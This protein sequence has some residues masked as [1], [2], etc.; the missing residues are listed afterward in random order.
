MIS[1]NGGLLRLLRER[2][3]RCTS[4]VSDRYRSS[5]E[6]VS[7]QLRVMKETQLLRDQL[8]QSTQRY[9]RSLWAGTPRFRPV[10]VLFS[11]LLELLF[12]LS[13]SSQI[14]QSTGSVHRRER[15]TNWYGILQ[16]QQR[17]LI[18]ADTF[19]YSPKK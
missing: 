17:V 12:S 16:L 15:Y 9:G 5:A 19:D 7:E 6:A 1:G 14:V 2:I 10:F 4:Q 18:V 11:A 8:K 3:L 13:L